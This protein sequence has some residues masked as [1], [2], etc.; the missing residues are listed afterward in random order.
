LLLFWARRLRLLL[1]VLPMSA[2]IIPVGPEFHDPTGAPNSAPR[3]IPVSA[4]FGAI[5]VGDQDSVTIEILI[6]DNNVE[7]TLWVRWVVDY[8]PF[9]L[10]TSDLG[11]PDPFEP[12]PN[13]QQV[14]HRVEHTILCQQLQ[15]LH[16]HRITAIVADRQFVLQPSN[17]YTV[18]SGGE[19]TVAT[20]FWDA[21]DCRY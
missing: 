11:S 14:L 17:P 1:F 4:D 21:R 9:V 19:T 16:M 15:P 10:G 12:S 2:C 3:I 5:V 18:Q 8:P 13:G 6:S 7:D 20:W